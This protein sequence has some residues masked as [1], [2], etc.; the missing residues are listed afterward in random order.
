MPYV[1]LTREEFKAS[2]VRA[3]QKA[4][5]KRAM[6]AP[7]KVPTTYIRISRPMLDELNKMADNYEWTQIRMLTA[8]IQDAVKRFIPKG[9]Q[10]ND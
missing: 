8:I 10:P 6:R 4:A 3:A 7:D 5:E 2:R 9:G 1:K